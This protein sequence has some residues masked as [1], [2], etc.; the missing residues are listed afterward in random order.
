VALAV[1]L[2]DLSGLL[3]LE[4][5]EAALSAFA[6]RA[7]ERALR[8][9]LAERGGEGDPAGF[10]VIALGKHGSR[11]TQLFERHRSHPAVRSDQVPRRRSEEP[12]EAAARIARRLVELLQVR[13]GD[14][15]V[16]RVDL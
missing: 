10:V 3:P 11:G 14:G 2:G 4:G 16:F 1:A 12:V 13:D 9:A 7:V 15:Y 8:V 6:D 5:V